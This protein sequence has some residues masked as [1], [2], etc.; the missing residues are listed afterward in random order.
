MGG[1]RVTKAKEI[2]NLAKNYIETNIANDWYLYYIQ[3]ISII[4]KKDGYYSVYISFRRKGYKPWEV[5]GNDL[6]H[7]KLYFDDN[8]TLVGNTIGWTDWKKITK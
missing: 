3:P 5:T 6:S 1:C 4:E 2:H 8:N 7:G